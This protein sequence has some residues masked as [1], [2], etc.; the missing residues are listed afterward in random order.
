MALAPQ[1]FVHL[2]AKLRLM[3]IYRSSTFGRDSFLLRILFLFGSG[4]FTS[5]G[6]IQVPRWRLIMIRW[7]YYQMR[8]H[9]KNSVQPMFE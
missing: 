6:S 1:P 3:D 9:K 5:S 4:N 2:I 7:W 8:T